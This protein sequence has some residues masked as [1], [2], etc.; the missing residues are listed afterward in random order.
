[1]VNDIL[2]FARGRLGSTMPIDIAAANLGTL[3]REVIDEVRSACPDSSIS[4]S[5]TGELDG[6]W[7]AER[8]KQVVSNLLL[9]A[10]EHGVG[11]TASVIARR[12]DDFVTLEVH[13]EGP[14]IPQ[15]SL[16]V[17]FDPLVRVIKPNQ[18]PT[19]LGLGLYIVNEIV[20]AH[21]GTIE[22]TSSQ[23]SG[24]SFIVR[25][26]VSKPDSH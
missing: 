9:N 22:V 11:K 4:F 16:G 5:A 24:T 15:E 17:I 20:R 19:G 7:D 21:G 12:E 6:Q 10:L 18:K 14:A 3:V 26:P 8:L 2:D 1:M 23:S 25:L 13:N